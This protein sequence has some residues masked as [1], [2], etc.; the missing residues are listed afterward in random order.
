MCA[1]SHTLPGLDCT[2][3]AGLWAPARTQLARSSEASGAVGA[4]PVSAEPGEEIW[5]G[6]RWVVGERTKAAALPHERAEL[7]PPGGPE[8]KLPLLCRG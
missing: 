7:G 3:P 8:M 4:S 1:S 6:A 5:L 2:D